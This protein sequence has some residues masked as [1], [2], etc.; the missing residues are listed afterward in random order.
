MIIQNFGNGKSFIKHETSVDPDNELLLMDGISNE[1]YA[2]DEFFKNALEKEIIAVQVFEFIDID[3]KFSDYFP[4][5]RN[6]EDGTIWENWYENFKN[7]HSFYLYFY[8][9][10]G[11]KKEFY[12]G[13]ID[14]QSN[15]PANDTNGE[16]FEIKDYFA[17]IE[18]STSTFQFYINTDVIYECLKKSKMEE[19]KNLLREFQLGFLNKDLNEN[20]N[21]NSPIGHKVKI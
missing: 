13:C 15:I 10:E 20:L 19:C 8:N 14:M 17:N 9:P 18:D 21:V 6:W 4:P 3:S 7:N 2:F 16:Y 11:R 12:I 5:K 1:L